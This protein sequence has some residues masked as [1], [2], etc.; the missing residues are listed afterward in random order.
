VSLV[1]YELAGRRLALR[2]VWM[3]TEGEADALGD[4]VHE[5]AQQAAEAMDEARIAMIRCE[6]ELESRLQVESGLIDTA[7]GI[8]EDVLIEM[9]VLRP[10]RDDER[11]VTPKPFN[12]DNETDR[13]RD[14]ERNPDS[15]RP[16]RS[17]RSRAGRNRSQSQR[18]PPEASH[19][20]FTVRAPAF[21]NGM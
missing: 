4:D 1:A 8:A 7:L 11:P 16:E 18:L 5:R 20:G 13:E 9:A 14:Q 2:D 19:S 10:R 15:P 17:H 12:E 6:M 21:L 3:A